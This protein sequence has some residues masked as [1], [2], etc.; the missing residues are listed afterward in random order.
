MSP[1][2]RQE[3]RRW[4]GFTHEILTARRELHEHLLAFLRIR[5]RLK[6]RLPCLWQDRPGPARSPA[7]ADAG[8]GRVVVRSRFKEAVARRVDKVLGEPVDEGKSQQLVKI[9]RP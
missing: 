4:T 3:F 9:H 1:D 7:D 8:A 2:D 6:V 5:D